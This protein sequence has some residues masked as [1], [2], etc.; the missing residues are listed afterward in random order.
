MDK[1]SESYFSFETN[2]LFFFNS[3]DFFRIFYAFF[4]WILN[5]EFWV[6]LWWNLTLLERSVRMIERTFFEKIALKKF[7]KWNYKVVRNIKKKF[8]RIQKNSRIHF[9][10]EYKCTW[11]CERSYERNLQQQK[12]SIK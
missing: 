8:L 7:Q 1:W 11:S 12:S 10:Y 3:A 9:I 2:L 5:N 4:Y 6:F